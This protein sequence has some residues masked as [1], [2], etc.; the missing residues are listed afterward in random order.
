MYQF[1]LIGYVKK[2]KEICMEA[3]E[4]IVE[5]QTEKEALAKAKKLVKKPNW[6]TRKVEKLHEHP[7]TTPIL[8]ELVAAI[9][10]IK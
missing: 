5:A 6:T 4:V 9:K 8:K 7:D 10:K 3:V 2:E 1:L